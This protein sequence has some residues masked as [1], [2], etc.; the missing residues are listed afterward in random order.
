MAKEIIL[1]KESS[2][3]E[4]KAYFNVV[5]KLSQSDNEFPINLDEVW[6]LVY[7]EKSKAVRALRDN[8]IEEV[9]FITMAQNGEGGRFASTDYYLTVSCMEFFIARKVRPVFEVY[10]QVFH[11]TAQKAIEAQ[12]KSKREPSLTTKV[13]V[14]LE[15]VK[16]VSE[17]LNLNDSSKLSLLGKVATPL[18]LP[19]PDY[20]PSK[21][22]VKSAT[23]L[24]KEK[25]LSISAQAFNQRAIQKGFLCEMKRKSS[26]GKDKP[27]KSITESGLLYGENQ[28]NPNNPK[29]T[30]PLWYEDKFIE[31]LGLLGFQLAKLS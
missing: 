19:T 4:I 5:L 3:S 6:P 28:V 26:H 25:G 18:G 30:Q 8:F 14:G 2:E 1:S 21:G 9:D 20:T 10:R 23:E 11:H 12:N 15:W 7:S 24:L 31:L 22:I 17:L 13:R 16:G 27:F 29:S